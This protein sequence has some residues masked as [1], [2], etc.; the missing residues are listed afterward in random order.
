LGSMRP[1]TAADQQSVHLRRRAP[2]NTRQES[3]SAEN[4]S[5]LVR[6]KPG[7]LSPGEDNSQYSLI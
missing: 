1:V 4:G 5:G 7:R 3:L 6:T 2:A